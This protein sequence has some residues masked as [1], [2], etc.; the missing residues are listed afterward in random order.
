MH[1]LSA[2]VVRMSHVHIYVALPPPPKSQFRG[3]GINR[4]ISLAWFERCVTGKHLR[5]VIW[6]AQFKLRFVMLICVH[7]DQNTVIRMIHNSNDHSNCALCSRVKTL[8]EE[9]GGSTGYE[10][11]WGS[12]YL[13]EPHKS[14]SIM[15]WD[16]RRDVCNET[17]PFFMLTFRGSGNHSRSL[18]LFPD[19]YFI[20]FF[21]ARHFW[22][23]IVQKYT[24]HRQICLAVITK[25]LRLA[26]R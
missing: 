21:F 9:F 13:R 1:C 23:M 6:I 14:T 5:T 26:R 19:F 4:A 10:C 12:H 17:V 11:A 8:F 18:H 20:F 7:T 22:W 2:E 24:S 3:Q 25:D 16:V 15:S